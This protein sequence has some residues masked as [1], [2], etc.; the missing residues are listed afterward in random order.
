VHELSTRVA[1]SV[2][3]CRNRGLFAN[4]D[5]LWRKRTRACI[6]ATASLVSCADAKL[7]WFGGISEPLGKIGSFE[8]IRE[9]SLTRTDELFVMRWTCLSLVTIRL[10]LEHNSV[11]KIRMGPVMESFARADDTGDND[12]LATAQKIDKT[13][14]NA[15]ECL[16]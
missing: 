12:A 7:A 2:E 15:S 11:V 14:K 6:E 8:K 4:N 5:G 10:I 16:L 9:L 3:I 1:R 13:L